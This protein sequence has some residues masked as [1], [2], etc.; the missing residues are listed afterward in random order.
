MLRIRIRRVK[1]HLLKSNKSR[2]RPQSCFS[3][4]EKSSTTWVEKTTIEL[5]KRDKI[6]KTIAKPIKF[7]AKEIKM[8]GWHENS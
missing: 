2:P 1:S 7:A 8:E 5:D 3:K 4:K 6:E